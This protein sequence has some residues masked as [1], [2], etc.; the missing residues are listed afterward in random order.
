MNINLPTILTITRAIL[1]PLVIVAFNL[2]IEGRYWLAGILF[3]IAGL[4]DYLDGFLA[5]KMKL[6][7]KFGAFLDP[8]ADKILV[9][10]VLIMLVEHYRTLW[11]TIPAI[12]IIYREIMVSGLREWMASRGERHKV[13]VALLGKLKTALQ[14]GAIEALILLPDQGVL[15]VLPW[16]E[17]PAKICIWAAMLLT[18]WSMVIYFYDARRSFD[19]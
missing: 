10:G 5:R 16:L 9:A 7:S 2:P 8:I 17:T 12:I 15:H 11:V 13:Q 14:M 3:F 18:V 19:E 6:S 4:T 1:A